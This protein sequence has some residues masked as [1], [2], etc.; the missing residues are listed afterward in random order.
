ML[1]IYYFAIKLIFFFGIVRSLVKF[2]TLAKHFLFL[3]ILYTAGV[4]LFSYVFI[5]AMQ[6]YAGRSWERR[7][8]A[9]VGLSPWLCWLIETLVLSTFYFKMLGRFDEGVAFWVLLLLGIPLVFF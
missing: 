7:M 1:V 2:D 9:T 3:G 8:S 6:G 4:A 5:V